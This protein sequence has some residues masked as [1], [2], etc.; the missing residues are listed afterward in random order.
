[1][2]TIEDIV[3]V[4]IPDLSDSKNPFTIETF[5]N[6]KQLS[7]EDFYREEVLGT[8]MV[9]EGKRE[10]LFQRYI[11]FQS[12]PAFEAVI[13]D[14]INKIKWNNIFL[15]GN[16][17]ETV[18]WILIPVEQILYQENY[19]IKYNEIYNNILSSFEID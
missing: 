5:L 18:H 9:I 14:T 6:E 10:P 17:P 8:T 19:L 1:M 16:K 7:L 2:R 13:N 15:Y 3:I 4:N 11:E 12:E